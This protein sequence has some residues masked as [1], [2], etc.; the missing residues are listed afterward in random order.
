MDR[1][2]KLLAWFLG[3]KAENASLLEEM[4]LLVLR[5]YCHW[6]RNYFPADSILVTKKLQR[7][8]EAHYDHLHQNLLELMAQLRRNFPFYSPRYFAHMLSDVLMPS[9]IGYLAGMLYNPNNVTPEAAPVTVDMEIEACNALLEMLGFSPPP[10]LPREYSQ[11]A[12][13]DY[14]KKLQSQFGWAH[15]TH[16]G[17][18]ANLEALWVARTI[19]YSPL[20]IWDVAR[21]EKLNLEIKLPSGK[22]KDIKRLKRLQL[23]HIKP[24]ESIYLL[25]KYV[26][27]FHS[28]YNLPLGDASQQAYEL[29]NESRYSL[30]RGIGQL[31][32]EFPP[33]I[34]ASGSAHYSVRKAADILG[35]G[36]D[37]IEDIHMDSAFRMDMRHLEQRL[38]ETLDHECIPLAVIPVAG[39]TE[40]GAIDPVHRV[41]DL[42][43]KFEQEQDVSFWIHVDAAWGGYMR[44]LFNLTVEDEA[45]AIAAK[46]SDGIGVK[47]DDDL[48]TWTAAFLRYAEEQAIG[49]VGRKAEERN[50]S[51]ERPTDRDSGAEENIRSRTR[52]AER[53]LANLIKTGS[54]RQFLTVLRK[55]TS[56]YR[57]LGVHMPEPQLS[58]QDRVNLVSEYVSDTVRLAR[59][60]YSRDIEVK[61]GSK[62]V[63]SALLAMSCADSIT[64]DPHKMGYVHYPCGLIAFRNDR[65]RHFI[66]QKAPYI[67]SVSQD[68]LVHMPPKHIEGLEST[69]K[70]VVEAFAPFI[71]EGS[72]PGAAASALWLTVKTIPPT[73]REGGAIVKASLLAAR[74]LYEWLIHWPAALRHNKEDVDYQFV[75]LTTQVP[76]TNVVIFAVKKRTSNSLAQMNALTQLVY[77]RFAI[78][79]ELGEREYSYSQPFFLS[80][81]TFERPSYP[82]ETLRPV[83][84]RF[85]EKS[86]MGQVCNEYNQHGLTVLRATVMNPYISF[87]NKHMDQHMLSEL[88]CELATAAL[89]SVRRL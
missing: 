57:A 17:T 42:R 68:V 50:S 13:D 21:R 86:H 63:C 12:I 31:F 66:L 4:L 78:Q 16:G 89:E 5:D 32:Q 3:P 80:K 23:L 72:R 19:K 34:F 59:G 39:T 14:K 56:E 85:F 62:E 2:R 41:V 70:V 15:L 27:A 69:P 82:F 79:A 77:E 1:D 43:R 45:R 49:N 61:W 44:S 46:I 6:R 36:K 75:P 37:R 67:T 51:D 84:S 29:L 11:K 47:F 9:T 8:L 38:Q 24:N 76:D 30:N 33:V 74:E 25:A 71:V 64:V 35:I 73:M 52:S 53:R 18:T 55:L 28:K 65:V 22:P 48:G 20:A 83:L 60:R 88:M 58:L 87:L 54:L 81:T 26:V 40:E 10:P 7:K